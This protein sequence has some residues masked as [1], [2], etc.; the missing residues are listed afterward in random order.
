MSAPANEQV[1]FD[2]SNIRDYYSSQCDY[3]ESLNQTVEDWET[4][5]ANG[6]EWV[7]ADDADWF[8]TTSNPYEG[9]NCK[10]SGN[11]DDNEITTLQITMQVAEADE[12]SF[13]YKVSSKVDWDYLQFFIS[14]A[15]QNA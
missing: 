7:N 4:G 5:T 9:L 12:I 11:V 3:T 6:F 15:M 1:D 13:S 2:F 10:Q 8:T 14:N